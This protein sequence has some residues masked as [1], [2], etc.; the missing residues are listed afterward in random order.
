A[1][2]DLVH[3][4]DPLD[5][6]ADVPEEV[7]GG[8]VLDGQ[9]TEATD[10]VAR[11]RPRDPVLGLLPAERVRVVPHVLVIG[12]DAMQRFRVGRDERPESESSRQKRRGGGHHDLLTLT[13][14]AR[15]GTRIDGAVVVPQYQM[16]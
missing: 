9:Q 8:G 4:V 7:A 10:L 1:E 11:P 2:L 12:L 5:R 13:R 14:T 15:S 6:G 16:P 3:A